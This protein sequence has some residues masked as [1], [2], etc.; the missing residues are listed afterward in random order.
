[1]EKLKQISSVQARNP[2]MKILIS[3]ITP[4]GDDYSLDISRQEFNRKLLKEFNNSQCVSICDNSICHQ[5]ALLMVNFM[6]K[7]IHLNQVGT[8]VL[9]G[10]ITSKLIVI[11]RK[12]VLKNRYKQKFKM[13]FRGK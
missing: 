5:E 10:N 3:N 11:P 2:D 7:A 12:Q 9:A 6:V 13:S 4:R 1:M 8:K